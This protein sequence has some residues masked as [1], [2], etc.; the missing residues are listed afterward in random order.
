MEPTSPGT[1]PLS[2]DFAGIDPGLMQSFIPALERGRDVIGEQSER[3]RQLLV[4]AEVSASGLQ[5]IKQIEGWIDD[6]LPGLRQRHS[7]I[8][9]S[10]RF[11]LWLPGAGPIAYD[12]SRSRTAEESR[13]QGT[14]LGE[15]LLAIG[16]V[17][18]WSHHANVEKYVKVL[19]ELDANKNDADFTAAF[20]AALGTEV[21]LNL[22]VLLRESVHTEPFRGVASP[23]DPDEPMLRTLSQAFGSAVMGGARVPGFAKIKTAVQSA[24]PSDRGAA[25]LLLT[26]GEFPTEWLAG[27]A[28]AWGGLADPRKITPGLL[29]AL[30]N[31]PAA[32]RLA[33]EKV[34][35]AYTK[36]QSKLKEFLKKLNEHAG[37]RYAG[38][39]QK[40]DAFGRMLAAASGA[41]DEQDGRHSKEAAAFAFA[42]M[43]TL[44]EVRIGEAARVHMAEI[45]GAYTTEI[46][47]GANIGD[48]NMTDSSALKP[49]TS[50]LG[51]KSAFTLSP[52]DTYAFMKVFADTDENLA[53]FEEGMGR[54]SQRLIADTLATTKQGRD[55]DSLEQA[56]DA[57][58]N[59]RGFEMAAAEKVR[60]TMDVADAQAQ[61]LNSFAIGATLGVTGLGVP[62]MAGQLTWLALGTGFSGKDAFLSEDQKRVDKLDKADGNATLG[63]QHALA[64][65][66]IANGFAPKVTPAEY[67][68]TC[69][70]GVAI[71][72]D[73][74]NLRPF[75]DL[76][77]QGDKGLVAFEKW[78]DA[79]GMGGRDR[80]SVGNLSSRMANWFEGGNGRGRQRALVFD[81]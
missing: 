16:P 38:G 60:G 12:E 62:G 15:R 42:V 77:K 6:E 67:Q 46:T 78:A 81:N 29:Y 36:D 64:Q 41:Y 48:A 35:G 18:F 28:S 1:G 27:V 66:L 53:P 52:G 54:F 55:T 34:T 23:P 5:P 47:E 61:K 58:G 68:A 33:V 44:D 72:D 20:F 71:A 74:G 59:V 40:A 4:A 75:P 80:F 37:G 11:A 50:A 30:G 25:D 3:I 19:A 7:T 57:L 51:L 49:T 13:K 17:G 32:A 45:A 31:N 39:A 63:R 9:E 24:N 26:T 22:P 76:L 2:P 70:P 65:T 69:P 14:T 10:D 79:N 56:L 8:R 21:A 73:E 43:T